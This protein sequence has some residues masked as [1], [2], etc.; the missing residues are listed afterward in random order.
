MPGPV[1]HR[2]DDGFATFIQFTN[3]PTIGLWEKTV[4][5]MG[6]DGG[7]PISTTTMRNVSLE[8]MIPRK[9]KK[10]TP[11]T[12]EAAYDEGHL[13]RIQQQ[14]NVNQVL[15]VIFPTG[16]P[17]GIWGALTNFEPKELAEGTQPTATC[18]IT[19]TMQDNNG[20]EQ[21][22]ILGTTSTTT[23]TTTTT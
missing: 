2:L 3:D 14:V 16:R 8:T 10:L 11:I 7:A 20:V 6:I 23:A 5:P 19:P 9:L 18:T 15:N 12:F 17:A 13:L 4:K 1:G 22:I 21:A